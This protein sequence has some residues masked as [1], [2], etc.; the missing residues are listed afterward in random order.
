MG[1]IKPVYVLVHGAWLGEY[2]WA[3]V[4]SQLKTKGSNVI[5]LDLPAHGNDQ[6]PIESVSLDSYCKAVI[7]AIADLQNVILVGHSMAGVII[8]VVAEAIP[9]KISSLVYLAAYLP[10]DGESLYQLSLEDKKSKVGNYWR[11]EDP[12]RYT[13]VWIA[14]EGI[15]E[16]FGADCPEKY[17]KL[18]IEYHRAEPVPPLATPV[19][20]SEA[21][22]GSIP[23]Y[24]IE[25]L[26][27]NTVS[28]Q[29]QTLMLRRTSVNRQFQLPSSHTPF[30]SMP[31]Q[32]VDC[33]VSVS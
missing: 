32:L 11:Q 27:D 9:H 2:C 25:T 16:V 10:Q 19:E 12:E 14:S 8:S 15:V 20:L 21:N 29:L 17:Q 3:E 23:R 6:S 1:T 7:E 18:L 13:P 5:T 30:F 31:E 33:L 22:Y 28:H 24:Y 26:N 4:V